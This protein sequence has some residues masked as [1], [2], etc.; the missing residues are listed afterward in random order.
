[1]YGK[2]EDMA[3]SMEVVTGTG[4]VLETGRDMG[5]GVGPSWT[6]LFI[7]SEG[8]LGFITEGTLK[9][10]PAPEHRLMHGYGFKRVSAGCE[11]I[12]R[13]M[14]AGLRPSVVR[15][16]DEFDTVLASSGPE[17]GSEAD[18]MLDMITGR[19][20]KSG[21]LP[22]LKRQALQ[23]VLSR[24]D[25]TNRMIDELAPRVS[26]DGCLCIIGWEGDRRLAEAQAR[27]GHEEL[28][29]SGGKDL[30]EEP[31]WHWFK[32]RYAVSYKQS[33]MFTNGAFVDTME[34]A[35]TWDRLMDLYDGVRKAIA[36][37]AFVMAH[38]SHAYPEGCSIY[39]SFAGP[40]SDPLEARQRYDRLWSEALA[41]ATRAGGTI[42]HHHGVG[43]SKAHFMTEEHGNSL[44][45]LKTLKSTFDPDGIMNPGVLGVS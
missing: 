2:I 30:G 7:G 25:L 3:V 36:P 16:Y 37:F 40:A 21:A 33:K 11:A 34:V 31:G 22:W 17:K 38:F 20:Q 4:E 14:Q 6:Q 23:I 8:S 24:P 18:S 45:L 10:H 1:M 13:L 42:S 27:L 29:R 15:L 41:A 44:R 26:T 5:G 39:F 19:A 43:R 9:V 35:A 12:R 28:I 32:R